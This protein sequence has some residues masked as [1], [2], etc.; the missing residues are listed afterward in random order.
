[1]LAR[2]IRSYHRPTRIEDALTLAAQGVVPMA[3]GTRLL[4]S[5]ID[6]PNVLGQTSEQASATL[7]GAGFQVTIVQV[8]VPANDPRN[9][10]VIT[11]SP[12]GGA[13]AQKG[14]T[15]TITVAVPPRR[16]M[17]NACSAVAFRPIASKL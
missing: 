13:K 10:K 6:V 7:T 16:S 12:A 11:Q 8:N 14:S 15:V 2:G 17:E 1:M 4:A 3:G 9:G 5:D